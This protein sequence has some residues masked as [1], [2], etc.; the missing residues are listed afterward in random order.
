M[1]KPS[2]ALKDTEL[3]ELIKELTPKIRTNSVIAGISGFIGFIC[4]SI[5]WYSIDV[6]LAL[7]RG[8]G[9]LVLG[10]IGLTAASMTG[11]TANRHKKKLKFA[12]SD[13]VV[14]CALATRF[15]I[16]RYSPSGCIRR[17]IIMYAGLIHRSWNKIS[18]SD[19]IEGAYKGIGFTFSDVFLEQVSANK[20]GSE[21]RSVVFKGQWLILELAKPLT[22]GVQLRGRRGGDSAKSDIETESME[23]NK[24]FQIIASNPH[25]AFYILTPQLIEQILKAAGRAN[26]QMSVSFDGD[27]MH[28]A[29]D[30]GRD[31]FELCSEK[32]KM[33][34]VNNIETLR[35]QMRWDVNYIANIIDELL[36]NETLFKA[37]INI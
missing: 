20:K 10:F 31:L 34:K 30:S 33:F 18:G 12:I 37:D 25:T 5:G 9:L 4:S 16:D 1:A 2:Y 27:K 35:M 6:Q 7:G 14:R 36:L 23:F 8:L 24:R 21:R 19:L 26:A 17:D 15:E 11:M 3:D 22:F 29:L 13:S 32:R 28:I